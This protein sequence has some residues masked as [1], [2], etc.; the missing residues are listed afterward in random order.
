[1]SFSVASE[2]PEK[3]HRGLLA[4]WSLNLLVEAY[5][6]FSSASSLLISDNS[7]GAI[8]FFLP[9]SSFEGEKKLYF[10]VASLCVIQWKG[11]E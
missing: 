4:S 10:V 5:C 1:M 8:A 3:Y 7:T 2:R 9:S 11:S 6:Q